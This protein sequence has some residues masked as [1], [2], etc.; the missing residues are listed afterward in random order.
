MNQLVLSKGVPDV[1]FNIIPCM[2]KPLRELLLKG[3][4]R[5]KMI[6]CCKLNFFCTAFCTEF[7]T[8]RF[9]EFKNFA[10][11]L[12]YLHFYVSFSS[13]KCKNYDVIMNIKIFGNS[14]ISTFL[15]IFRK[16]IRVSMHSV[17]V[18][19]SMFAFQ[20]YYDQRLWVQVPPAVSCTY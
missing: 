1:S 20:S 18:V 2:G 6:Y 17:G 13:F 9:T 5:Y 7:C 3:N 12:R 16:P 15:T 19:V 4:F 8:E 10:Q 14:W 11:F